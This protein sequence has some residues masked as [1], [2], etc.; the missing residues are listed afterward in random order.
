MN[1]VKDFNFFFVEKKKK[2]TEATLKNTLY[3]I[4]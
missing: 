4:I 3:I 2:N 1:V